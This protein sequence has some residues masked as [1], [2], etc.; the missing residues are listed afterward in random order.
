MSYITLPKRIV[1]IKSNNKPLDVYVW[2]MIRSCSDYR[3]GVSHITIDR[4]E[5]IT[6]INQR[7]IRRSIRRLEEA[8]LLKISTYF[9]DEL[10]RRN[11][12][13]TSFRM[14]DFFMLDREFLRQ[15]YDPKILGFILLLKSICINGANYTGWNKQEIAEGIGMA[16]N[17]VSALLDECLRYNLIT[18][19]KG[20]YILMED[21]FIND[22]LRS[23]D[24]E[25]F[26]TLDKFCRDRGSTLRP[27]K[28]MSRVALEMIGSRY[29]PLEN[30]LE[31]PQLDLRHNLEKSC[32]PKLPK[33]VSIE[34]FLKP[35]K[36][37]GYYDQYLREKQNRHKLRESYP[38]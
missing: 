23:M 5:Q 26:E 18:Q 30:Y 6:L 24:R 38:M 22:S 15:K 17:T 35:L 33:E 13:D 20:R 9:V 4:L 3:D 11:S 16:R 29:R 10:T 27:Y 31:N 34:Y 8:G 25:I 14:R 37:Q 12:Y 21:Y 32:P 2:A 28:S 19:D 1:Q 7:T 36:L